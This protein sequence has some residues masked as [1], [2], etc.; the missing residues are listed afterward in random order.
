MACNV[1]AA[2]GVNCKEAVGG[3]KRIFIAGADVDMVDHPSWALTSGKV[4]TIPTTAFYQWDFHP[5]KCTF[6]ARI[7]A[8]PENGT[9]YYEQ[10]LNL[11]IAHLDVDDQAQLELLA[12]GKPVIIVQL[13]TGA[14]LLMGARHGCDVSGGGI[15]AGQRF[16][17][18]T[19]MTLEIGAKEYDTLVWYVTEGD[20]LSDANYPLDNLTGA[21]INA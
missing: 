3:V 13:N 2:V 11:N 14:L 1:T 6:E 16:G 8:S 19:E 20:D 21:S 10:T 5:E 18:A 4:S 12:K 7:M 9:L 17:D 15:N